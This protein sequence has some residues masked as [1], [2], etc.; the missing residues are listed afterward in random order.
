MIKY[1]E[2]KDEQM[3]N[4]KMNNKEDI[5][6]L[7]SEELIKE[8][9]ENK[10]KAARNIIFMAAAAVA[11][12][13]FCIAWFVSNTR[14][15]GTLGTV[16]AKYS[17]IEIG[18]EGAKGVHD[19][20]LQKVKDAITYHLPGENSD[21]RHDT[22]QGGS[23]N[24]LLSDDSNMNNYDNGNSFGDTGKQFRKDYAMEPGTK[25]KL[26]FF[27]RSYDE[28]D[29]SLEF[30]LDII[31]FNI[32]LTDD[33][34]SPAAVNKD[35]VEAKLLSGHILYFLGEK[36]SDDTVKYT[37]IK[38]GT[39]QIKIPGAEKD[40]EYNYSIYWVWPLNLS[41]VLLNTGDEFLNG[42]TVEFDDKDS[43]GE[44]RKT[45]VADMSENPD[46]Y[47]FSSMTGKPLDKENYEEVKAISSIHEK[48]G[49]NEEYDRQLFVDL[50]SYYN[51]AD[52]KIGA[53]ISFVTATLEYLGKSETTNGLSEA[54]N[55]D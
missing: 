24:W 52:M 36:Q 25:G 13:T 54:K 55:E 7:S 23:I 28:G 33:T 12:I 40:T 44:L 4:K 20:F 49:T 41:T 1:K 53:G 47:F 35:S 21:K 22:S 43:T 3:I 38:D 18:S 46:K 15:S 9:K 51:Q 31:P 11:I 10:K 6:Q 14:V 26:D 27:I 50:S 16:S 29:L 48:S 30:S 2:R 42:N 32:A 37:W 8:I 19:D 45:I 39:F 34:T 5:E 17:G